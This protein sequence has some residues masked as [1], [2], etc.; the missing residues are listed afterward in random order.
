MAT[1]D[2]VLERTY[3][4]K[5]QIDSMAVL[6]SGIKHKLDEALGGGQLSKEQQAKV[7]AVFNELDKNTAAIT[8]AIN[9]NDDDP[10]NDEPAPAPEPV[11]APVTE[12]P[13]PAPEPVAAADPVVDPVAEEAKG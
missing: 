9:A 7:D 3:A 6:L 11:P 10:S 13:A 1:L 5:G 2:D 8:K 12:D 4:Q